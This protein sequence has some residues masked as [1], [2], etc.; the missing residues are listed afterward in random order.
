MGRRGDKY[1]VVCVDCSDGD[2]EVAIGD[3]FKGR[4]YKLMDTI[5]PVVRKSSTFLCFEE[6]DRMSITEAV[7][8]FTS[9]SCPYDCKLHMPLAPNVP[10]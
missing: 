5:E 6:V 9:S 3:I 10:S 1:G 7:L 8:L 4:I 2:S